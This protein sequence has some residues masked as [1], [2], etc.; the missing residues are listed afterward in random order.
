M[1]YLIDTNVLSEMT[2]SN[3]NKD[4]VKWFINAPDK[5]K[6][7]SVISIGEIIYGIEKLPN[8]PRKNKLSVWFN[9]IISEGFNE[10]ILDINASTM[11]TWGKMMAELP[12]SLQ[13]Q[14]TFIAATAIESN[15]TVVTRNVKDFSDIAGLK[16]LNPWI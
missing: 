9:E 7:I 11:R 8:N 13:V 6:F 2:K 3:P 4:V 12:R 14:D 1:K 16:I 10:R 5:D 15:L